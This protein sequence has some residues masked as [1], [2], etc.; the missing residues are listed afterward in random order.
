MEHP[1]RAV[2]KA[3]GMRDWRTGERLRLDVYIEFLLQRD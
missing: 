3:V 2:Q 1:G